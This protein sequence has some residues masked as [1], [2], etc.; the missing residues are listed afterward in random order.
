MWNAEMGRTS[1][2]RAE[3]LF[4]EAIVCG[5][6]TAFWEAEQH[7]DLT[8]YA[9]IFW[10]IS[11][12]FSRRCPPNKHHTTT[13]NRNGN[14]YGFGYC[15]QWPFTCYSCG[16][17]LL[18]AVKNLWNLKASVVRW[19]RCTSFISCLY[20]IFLILFFKEGKLRLNN[21]NVKVLVSLDFSEMPGSE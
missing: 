9:F 17:I 4:C 15:R 19:I 11:S 21:L 5:K 20:V 14:R 12:V 7:K 13:A 16:I 6:M 18:T 10:T 1:G 8:L 2:R 3:R